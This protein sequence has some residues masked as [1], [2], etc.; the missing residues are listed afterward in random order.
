M[1]TST[2]DWH[3]PIDFD[4]YE[5]PKFPTEIFPDWL[6]QYVESIADVSQTPTDA[7]GIAALTILS[8]ALAKKFDIKPFKNGDWV[9]KNNIYTVTIMESGE[10]KSVIHD[11]FVK[12]IIEYERKLKIQKEAEMNESE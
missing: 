1:K 4:S 7:S 8:A 11:R 10:R 2:D 6:K 3:E 5:L 9:E 12:P